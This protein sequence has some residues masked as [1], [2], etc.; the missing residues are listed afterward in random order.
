MTIIVPY[1]KYRNGVYYLLTRAKK[2]HST[3]CS[4]L[5][6]NI[7][8]LMAARTSLAAKGHPV[9]LH[10]CLI[11]ATSLTLRRYPRL[12]H[13]LFHGLLRKY[14]VDFEVISCNLVILRRAA[15]EFVLL[16]VVLERSDELSVFEIDEVIQYHQKAPVDELPQIADL[17]KLRWIPDIGMKLISYKLRSNYRFYRKYFGTYVYSPLIAEDKCG[18]TEDRMGYATSIV[19][20]VCTAFHPCTIGDVP[21]LVDGQVVPQKTLSMTVSMDHYLVDAHEGLMAMRHLR[22]LLT[23]PE[24]IELPGAKAP[25]DAERPSKTRGALSHKLR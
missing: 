13:H 8:E 22:R 19:A 6:F 3:T 23:T 24:W 14:E 7:S 16:P 5:D 11:K 25:L 4:V 10:A 1:T 9:S 2:F 12:N 17:K 18:V 20:N 21:V 15:G